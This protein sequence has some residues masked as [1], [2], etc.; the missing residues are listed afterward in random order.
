M[1]LSYP[2]VPFHFA[3]QGFFSKD[4]AKAGA[5]AQESRVMGTYVLLLLDLQKYSDLKHMKDTPANHTSPLAPKVHII[6]QH[7]TL[8]A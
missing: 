6:S 8:V 4:A 3:V 2:V 5:Y 7:E 1:V